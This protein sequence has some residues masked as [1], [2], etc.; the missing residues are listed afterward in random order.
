MSVRSQETYGNRAIHPAETPLPSQPQNGQKMKKNRK[1]P[2]NATS[3]DT[4]QPPQQFSIL[5]D[6]CV[7]SKPVK[8]QTD[9][10]RAKTK[11]PSTPATTSNRPTACQDEKAIN[12]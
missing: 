11:K 9:Q 3:G 6:N 2:I 5:G 10:Q 8:P 4:V 7:E 1:D 12:A